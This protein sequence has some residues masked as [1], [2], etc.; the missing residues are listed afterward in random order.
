MKL[1]K[2]FLLD[3]LMGLQYLFVA[4]GATILVPLITG[5][6]VSVCLFTAGVGTLIFHLVTKGKVPVLLSSSFAFIAPIMLVKQLYGIQ[7]AFGGIIVA[8]LLYIALA[9]LIYFV[10]IKIIKKIFPPVITATMV[11][12]IGIILAP[13]AIANA[14]AGWLIAFITLAA[15]V[16]FK[17]FF[18]EKFISSMSVIVAIIVGTLVALIFGQFDL[19][20]LSGK[21]FI[22]LPEFMLPVFSWKA[23]LIIAPIA[24]VTFLEHFADVSAVS[25]VVEKDFIADPGIHRTLIG[26]GIATAFAGLVGGVPNTTYSENIGALEMTGVKKP[27]VLRITAVMLIVFSLLPM[28]TSFL[29]SIPIAVI[30]GISILLFGLISANGIKS[31]AVEKIDFKDFRNL[32]IISAMLIIGTGGTLISFGNLTFSSL[33][34]AALVGVLLNLGMNFKT[35]I[36]K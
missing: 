17:L 18:K 29:Q 34:L 35:I 2:E 12:L 25:K 9:V 14:S 5:L 21:A 3:F 23:I 15:G 33:A 28:L 13:V 16:F 24:F 11:I 1:K 36:K 27:S 8:G 19:T 6:P 30:G 4:A 22:A 31:L 7:A 10:G 32:V 26:D 20:A